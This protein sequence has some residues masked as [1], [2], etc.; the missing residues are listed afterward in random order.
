ML[1]FRFYFFLFS[2][3]SFQL[4]VNNS[5]EKT[6]RIIPQQKGQHQQIS[7]AKSDWIVLKGRLRPPGER[8][9]AAYHK[10]SEHWFME[11]PH[12]ASYRLLH[13]FFYS[14]SAGGAG[15]AQSSAAQP[16]SSDRRVMRP[17]HD[18]GRMR[19]CRA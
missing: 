2:L 17:Y 10:M 12:S 1:L 11:K 5:K 19:T 7:R 8:Q 6:R 4:V 15:R 13:S 18:Q 16:S 14:G 3:N 9:L